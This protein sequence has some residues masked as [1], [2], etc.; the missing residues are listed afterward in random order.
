MEEPLAVADAA[1]PRARPV[2]GRR[3]D[4]ERH[5][6]TPSDDKRKMEL[7]LAL[8]KVLLEQ[9]GS[10]SARSRR[11]RA[12][13]GDRSESAHR[14]RRAG[15]AARG[16]RRRHDG[17]AGHRNAGPASGHARSKGRAMDARGQ[18]SRRRRRLRRR[19]RPLQERAR[20]GAH[21]RRSDRR[22]AR[23]IHRAR[24][25][26]RR[27]RADRPAD[28]AWP[29][30][31]A[32]GAPPGG[33]GATSQ[34]EAERRRSRERCRDAGQ[35][36]RPDQRRC[37]GRPRRLRLRRRAVPRGSRAL[38]APANRADKLDKADATRVLVR[39][40]DSLYKTGSSEKALAPMD[41]LLKIAPNDA[42]ALARVARVLVRSR[43]SQTRLRALSR[44]ARSF[45]RPPDPNRG[46]RVALPPRRIGAARRIPRVRVPT[47]CRG[48]R[49][50]SEQRRA[51]RRAGQAVPG[52]G[53]LGE[54]R[55]DE[56]PAARRRQRRRAVRALARDRRDLHRPSS[57]I[58]RAP[59]RRTSSR[60]RNVPK[61]ATSSPS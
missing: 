18:A 50:R 42:E 20:C 10:P 43:R 49:S 56:E 59:P 2:G 28:R 48:G 24:R 32:E 4:D 34:A 8:G 29:R 44:A 35:S 40:V 37:A 38:R 14:A 39:Y 19:H 58:A 52:G 51:A 47:A 6:E 31:A 23:R 15:Q 12:R 13:A 46:I 41:E 53:R 54:R 27:S 33:V 55:Q 61:T 36:A 17:A 1:L 30:P 9:I 11:L 3:L 60:S 25:C 45:P 22:A 16:Q 5:L 57:T 21:A 7:L 26:R